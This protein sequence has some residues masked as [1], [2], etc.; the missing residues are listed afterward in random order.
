MRDRTG[1]AAPAALP[2]MPAP[3]LGVRLSTARMTWL[4]SLCLFPAA[5]WGVFLFGPPALGVLI[6]SV[7]TAALVELAATLPFRRFTLAD[8]SAVLTGCI[9]GLL[10]PAAVPL[11]VPAAASGFGILVI[12]QSFGGLGRNWMNPAMGGIVFASLSWPGL[13]SRWV[14]PRGGAV[15]DVA[16][17]PLEALRAALA[18]PGVKDG[19]PLEIL[20]RAGYSFSG[21]DTSVVGW[22]NVHLLGPMGTGLQPG[23]F[24]VLVGHMAGGIGSVCAPLLLLGAWYLLS[25][26]VIRWHLPVFYLGTFFVL[27]AVFG[28]LGAGK[29]WFAGGPVFQLLSGSIVLGAF[30]AAPDPVTS[31]LTNRGKCIFG[32]GLGVL[33]FFLRYYGSLGDG[34]AASIVLANC[35]APLLDRWASRRTTPGAGEKAA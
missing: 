13:L 4:V 32:I 34:V 35:A 16:L 24:D 7:G 9:V 22:I 23:S 29:G 28:G 30:Y 11:Y 26:G 21:T 10:M 27:A 31:P 19:S 8:G 14:A 1:A 18:G 33:T 5:L 15:Q 12:K 2:L 20:S 17:P 6:V 3:H 25:R